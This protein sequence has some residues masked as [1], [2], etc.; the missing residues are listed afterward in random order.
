[1]SSD[2]KKTENNTGTLPPEETVMLAGRPSPQYA[3]LASETDENELAGVE[4]EPKDWIALTIALL[5]TLFLPLL[6][7]MG[8]LLALSFLFRLLGS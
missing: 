4:L 5:Q 6:I 3:L 1:M 7:I 8:V 2:E